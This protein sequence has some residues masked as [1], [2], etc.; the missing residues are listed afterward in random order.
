MA[1]QRH[2]HGGRHEIRGKHP[3]D[4]VGRRAEAAE[5]VRRGHAHDGDVEHFEDRGEHD[6]HNERDGGLLG[7]CLDR[8]GRSKLCRPAHLLALGRAP[9][10]LLFG[11]RVDARQA[12]AR[13]VHRSMIAK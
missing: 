10:G 3:I 9:R 11:D 8:R 2:D 4:L 12:A 5:H 1:G 6:G 7:R 13:A